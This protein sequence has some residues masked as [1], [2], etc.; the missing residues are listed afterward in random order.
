MNPTFLV[1]TTLFLLLIS[2]PIN[3]RFVG[4]TQALQP[5]QHTHRNFT[6]L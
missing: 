5:G 2:H 1:L 6:G 3:A 4:F